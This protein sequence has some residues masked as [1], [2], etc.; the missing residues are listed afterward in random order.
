MKL[1]ELLAA[2]GDS[3]VRFQKLD[4]CATNLSMNKNGTKATFM[5]PETFGYEGFDKLGLVIWLD[6]ERAAKIIE[7]AKAS[8]QAPASG[9]TAA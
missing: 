5:T 3:D 9:G 8:S 4:D 2:Y 1:S 6:R 7:S